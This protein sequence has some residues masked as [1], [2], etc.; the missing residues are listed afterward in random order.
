[1]LADRI[2]IMKICVLFV[3]LGDPAVGSMFGFILYLFWRIMFSPAAIDPH[4]RKGQAWRLLVDSSGKPKPKDGSDGPIS[5]GPTSDSFTGF[6][7]GSFG[8]HNGTSSLLSFKLFGALGP[9]PC[10]ASSCKYTPVRLPP[11]RLS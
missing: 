11:V 6:I 10:P 7:A 3:A 2:K 9:L 1:M 5:D 4:S 8:D